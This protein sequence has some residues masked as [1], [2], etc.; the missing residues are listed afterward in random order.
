MLDAVPGGD[1]DHV[2]RLARGQA[3]QEVKLGP[4]ETQAVGQ[5]CEV[6][7]AVRRAVAAT[8]KG[9]PYVES[10]GPGPLSAYGRTKLGGE[11]ATALVNGR[12]FIVRTSWLF[13]PHGSNFVETM[14]RLGKDGGP[15]VVVRTADGRQVFLPVSTGNEN[16]GLITFKDGKM[17]VLRVPYPLGFYTRNLAGRIDDPKTGWKGKGLWA[18]YG[19]NLPWHI[20]GGKGTTSKVVKFQLRPDPLAR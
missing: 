16:D 18:D 3:P 7:P 14:L 15:V 13:G 6:Q 10:D 8:R 12:S 2:G 9:A 11:R 1:A 20:E 17:I 5:D 4:A 19:T